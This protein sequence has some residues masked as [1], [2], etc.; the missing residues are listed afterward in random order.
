MKE[1]AR[2]GP[3]HAEAPEAWAVG[4]VE[5]EPPPSRPLAGTPPRSPPPREAVA[6]VAPAC[7]TSIPSGLLCGAEDTA[8]G[9]SKG[10]AR[11]QQSG[12]PWWAVGLGGGLPK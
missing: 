7:H 1:P 3:G 5:C 12:G 6:Y 8:S 10:Y 4:G 2:A 9:D 11:P